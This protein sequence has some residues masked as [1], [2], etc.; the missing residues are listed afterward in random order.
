MTL[1]PNEI[2]Y[3]TEITKLGPHNTQIIFKSDSISLDP[4]NTQIVIIC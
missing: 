4:Q 1:L 3:V 2:L